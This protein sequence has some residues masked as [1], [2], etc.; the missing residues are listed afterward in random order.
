MNIKKHP[1]LTIGFAVILIFILAACSPASPAEETTVEEAPAAEEA[2]AVEETSAE[3]DT[4]S[5]EE[6]TA[7]EEAPAEMDDVTLRLSWRWKTEFAPLVLADDLGFFEE[8]GINMELLEGSG[9]GDVLPLVAQKEDDFGYLNLTT[10]AIG[11][12]KGMPLQV[13]AG[14]MGKHPSGLAYF[15]DTLTGPKDLEGKTIALS[16]GEAFAMI[17]PAFSER[18]DIDTETIDQVQLDFGAKNLAFIEGDIDIL[19]VYINNELPVLRGMTD[20]EINVLLPAEYEFNTIAN[21]IITH[22]DTVRDNPDLVRRIVAAIQKGYEYALEHPE[23]AVEAVKAR[24]EALAEQ[25]EAVLLNQVNTTLEL[26]YSENTEGEPIGWMSE[27]D[28]NNTLDLLHETGAT[29]GRPDNAD[30]FTNEFVPTE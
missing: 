12:D 25:D 22:D 11:I 3:E 27:E 9:S 28:W 16:P 20:R 18:W 4:A 26:I 19:P 7:A 24:S 1:I 10:V 13:V 29:D 6:E 30:V 2:P 5:T 17:Y 15:E 8:Q 21:G 14:L 23:E